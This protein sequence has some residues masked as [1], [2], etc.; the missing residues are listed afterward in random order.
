MW[1]ADTPS[2]GIFV[3]SKCN[4]FDDW[5]Q[6]V[7]ER[8]QI[9]SILFQYRNFVDRNVYVPAMH[10]IEDLVLEMNFSTGDGVST[11]WG[12]VYANW[13]TDE[14]IDIELIR[15]VSLALVSVM[16]CTTLLIANLPICLYIFVTVLLTLVRQH[17]QYTSRANS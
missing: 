9:S 4:L 14:V 8:F 12:K 15:N 11:V 1:T 17:E 7:F 5:C 10:A 2:E 3:Y 6:W 13:I 16:V